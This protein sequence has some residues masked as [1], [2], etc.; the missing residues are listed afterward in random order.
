MNKICL[1]TNDVETT[2]IINHRLNDDTARY[3]LEQGMP[4]LL[5]LYERHGVKATFFFTGHIAKIY[6]EIVKIA[7]NKGHE[8]GSHGLTHEVDKAF[9]I[10][11]PE[12][13][14]SH[15]KQSKQILEDIVGTEVISFRA[16]A[17]RVDKTFPQLLVESGYKIDSSVSSQRL[18]MMFSFGALKKLHWLTA[19][20]KAYFTQNGNIFK[21]GDSEILEI[22]I[23]A[24]GFPYIG[25]FMRIA[26]ILNRLT[27]CI[28]WRETCLTGRQFVFL[29]H[30]NEFIDE[31]RD[32]NPIERRAKNPISYLMGDVIRHALKVHNLGEKAL[33]LLE[34]ELQFF[35]NHDFQFL[36]CKEMY[37][38]ESN[39]LFYN[40]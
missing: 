32:N 18:D 25:T 14:L 39:H 21:K 16:P 1:I 13:Q 33:P 6:P 34:H 40:P 5:E 10:L 22:P 2:S 15:L 4:R 3:V 37:Q 8:V 12:E 9:D 29:T 20:R 17:A 24:F 38:L 7:F 35:T 27:R 26:P 30:P 28:L 11:T 19:P 31:P 36:T 23:S